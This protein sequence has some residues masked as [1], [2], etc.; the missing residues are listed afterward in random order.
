MIEQQTRQLE[1]LVQDDLELLLHCPPP[2]VVGPLR[3]MA[4]VSELLEVVL[5]LA[6]HAERAGAD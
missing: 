3:N 2:R 5:D 6:R 1:R 4:D